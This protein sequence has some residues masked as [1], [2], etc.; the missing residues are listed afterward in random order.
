MPNLKINI[1][2]K[3]E[4]SLLGI[5]EWF[6]VDRDSETACIKIEDGKCLNVLT[7]KIFYL[8]DDFMICPI[9]GNNINITINM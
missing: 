6:C 7:K 9:P 4:F 5:G 3:T 1:I 8:P 2:D